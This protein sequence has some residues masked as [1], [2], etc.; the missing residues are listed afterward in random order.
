MASAPPPARS[1]PT[2]NTE[3]VRIIG[4]ILGLGWSQANLNVLTRNPPPTDADFTE[5]PLMHFADPISCVPISACYPNAAVP[6][7]DDTTALT[8]LYPA[9]ANPQTTG[10]IYGSV[11]FT[12]A[13][14][15]ALQPMQGVN[16][17]ITGLR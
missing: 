6:A 8:R 4:R 10:K 12:D 2:F 9:T 5:F 7:M 3:L 15:N 17:P 1:C 14:G 11:Y 13:S 16:M